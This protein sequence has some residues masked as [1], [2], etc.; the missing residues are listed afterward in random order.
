MIAALRWVQE[1]IGAFG[2]DPANVTLGGQS[3][4][5]S[6]THSLTASPLARGLFHRAIA[7]SG[8]TV[9][10]GA[11]TRSLSE[12]EQLGVKFAEAKGARSLADLRGLSWKDLSAPVTA[13]ASANGPAPNFRFGV[14]I[15]GYVL[16]ASVA[17]V[18][19]SGKQTDVPTLTG[20]NKHEGGA[21]PHPEITA[22]AFQKQ[23]R[24]RFGDLADEFLALY[25]SATDEQA[26]LV[27]NESSWDQARVSMYLWA[28]NRAR[29]AKTKAYT[30][31]WDHPLP[32]P[33]V[34][35]YGAFHTSE[36]PYVM[37]AL[38]MS[39]RPF[40]DQDR[41]I[42][43]TLSSYWA[44]FIK[45]GDPNGP[46]LPN[47]PAVAK[48]PAMTMEIGDKNAPIPVAGLPGRLAFFEKFFG[49]QRPA[50]TR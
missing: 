26:R 8:S 38:A 5:A 48:A 9:A 31:F 24:Q 20:A 50:G 7:E 36:V 1:S 42:A 6:N 13:P 46:G 4:G 18:F 49:R 23:A 30:Y 14:V 45:T 11:G 40:T 34:E 47:W 37:N 19:A 39:N 32:G 3:A 15:D 21:T 12:Q 2:G 22:D 44:N 27:Q 16:P 33:D 10:A 17:D 43:D 28:M 41:R 35:K 25:P 29:T